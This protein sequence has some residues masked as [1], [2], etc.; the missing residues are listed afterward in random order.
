MFVLSRDGKLYMY[1]ITQ[2][3][4]KREELDHFG[5]SAIPKIKGELMINDP[6]VHIKDLPPVK[7]IA[8]GLDHILFVTNDG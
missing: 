1:K 4:P 7:Q 5:A 8:S 6:P 3:F 2:H